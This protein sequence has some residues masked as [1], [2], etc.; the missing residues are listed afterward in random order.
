MSRMSA[1]EYREFLMEGTRTAML[2]TVRKDGRPHVAPIWFVMDGED[3]IFGTGRNTVKGHALRR[4]GRVALSVDDPTPPF[5][6]VMI[7]GNVSYKDCADAPEE[8]LEWATRIAARYVG[9]DRAEA[10]GR[11]N[12]VAGELL[13]RL[14]PSKVVSQNDMLA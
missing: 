3:I 6:F 11:R 9:E 12:A 13:V 5:A 7:E 8:G 2:A 4:E 10:F 14:T 1:E